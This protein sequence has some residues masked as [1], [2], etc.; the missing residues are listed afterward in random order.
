MRDTTTELHRRYLDVQEKIFQNSTKF[1]GSVFSINR[2]VG[3]RKSSQKKHI[4][5]K[6]RNLSRLNLK[7]VSPKMLEF[8]SMEII[9]PGWLSKIIFCL[10]WRHCDVIIS[11]NS[12]YNHRIGTYRPNQKAVR[13]ES[14]DPEITII[15]TSKQ[16]PKTLTLFGSN[17][18]SYKFLLKAGF[19]GLRSST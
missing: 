5:M 17:G 7:K 12:V 14:I 19:H 13:V 3:W 2:C 4:Q 16:K 8:K 10:E 6:Q 11:A 1:K 18:Q 9:I 15:T